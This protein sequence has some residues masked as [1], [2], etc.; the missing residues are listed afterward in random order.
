MIGGETNGVLGFLSTAISSVYRESS[1]KETISSD[2][3]F[4][5]HH[6]K[7]KVYIMKWPF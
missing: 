5:L 6:I 7:T 1:E 4:C 2:W 3:Q